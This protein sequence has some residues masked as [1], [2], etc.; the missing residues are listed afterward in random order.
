[1]LL[2]FPCRERP[3]WPG[4]PSPG[5]TLATPASE[6]QDNTQYQYTAGLKVVRLIGI[7]PGVGQCN[8]K[9]WDE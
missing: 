1:M 2:P 9:T 8:A 7:T 6:T 3:P 4:P 5:D